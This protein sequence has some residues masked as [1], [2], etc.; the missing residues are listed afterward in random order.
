MSNPW[1]DLALISS[2]GDLGSVDLATVTCSTAG[3]VIS[4]K[5]PIAVTPGLNPR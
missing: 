1:G 4:Y 5:I 3:V 2:S